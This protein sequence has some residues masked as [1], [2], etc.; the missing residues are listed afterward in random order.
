MELGVL[1]V[2][3]GPIPDLQ[4][5]FHQVIVKLARLGSHNDDYHEQW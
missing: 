2:G 3:I 4:S 1:L 5:K